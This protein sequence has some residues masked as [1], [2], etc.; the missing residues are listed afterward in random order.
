[1]FLTRLFNYL[2]WVNWS[3]LFSAAV[4][5]FS[6]FLVLSLADFNT[7]TALVP[8]SLPLTVD[9]KERPWFTKK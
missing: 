1:M 5:T 2:R 4:L 3:V 6:S 8:A 7:L 9:E